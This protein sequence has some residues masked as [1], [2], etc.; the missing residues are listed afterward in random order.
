MQIW[1]SDLSCNYVQYIS[2]KPSPS[3]ECYDLTWLSQF[4]FCCC[5]VFTVMGTGDLGARQVREEESETDFTPRL[6]RG[7]D[8]KL[9]WSRGQ[10]HQPDSIDMKYLALH[11][12]HTDSSFCMISM[13]AIYYVIMSSTMRL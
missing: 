7:R 12:L 10:S 5:L 2:R 8:E 9:D 13:F 6:K 11:R 4:V 1:V 3:D